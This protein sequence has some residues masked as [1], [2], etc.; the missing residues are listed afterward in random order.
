MALH[1]V[2][3]GGGYL[4][5]HL[6]ARL[7]RDGHK[8]RAFDLALSCDLPREVEFVRG[9]VLDP[10]ALGRATEGAAVV[11]HLAFIQSMSRRPAA[12]QR[13]VAIDG[14]RNA[15]EAALRAGVR[16]FVF[17]STIEI[18]GTHP[19]VPCPEDAPKDPVG[20]YGALKW[21]AE[22]M[23]FEFGRARGLEVSATRMPLICGRGFYNQRTVLSLL[24]R[25]RRG[26]T[27][28]VTGRGAL[29]GEFVHVADVVE[30]YALC[31]S[32]KEAAGEA[33]NLASRA[34]ATQLEI[35][36]AIAAAFGGRSRIVRVPRPL[37]KIALPF[38]RALGLTELP[39]EADGYVLFDNCYSIEKA[40]RLLGYEPRYS[41]IEA[42]IALAKGYL[43]DAERVR[44]RSLS[45]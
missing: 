32:R 8:V 27:L 42:A 23:A 9:D 12:E 13:A 10:I 22:T 20:L 19:P 45:Y 43:E 37:A 18:Y 15:L 40:R 38:G 25:A 30:G 41:T 17:T 29:F 5:S 24:E 26:K 34:P 31:A 16:R 14:T 33:F 44:K 3:G 28:A 7:L 39:A 21:E 4:G 6:A 11:H 1:L 2:T 36:A 35:V